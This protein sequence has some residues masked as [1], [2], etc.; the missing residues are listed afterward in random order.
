VVP[1][2]IA[3]LFPLV[4]EAEEY[5]REARPYGVVLG[6]SGLALIAWQA[7]AERPSRRGFV[8][9]GLFLSVAAAVSSHYYAVLI[10]VPLVL[11]ELARSLLRR[12]VDIPMWL[13]LLAGVLPLPLHLPL[14]RIATAYSDRC[15]G[16]A[17]LASIH[18]FYLTL[19][20]P[21]LAGVVALAAIA[22]LYLAVADDQG[23]SQGPKRKATMPLYENVMV[24][25]LIGMPAVGVFLAMAM[26]S[27]FTFRYA[28]AATLGFGIVVASAVSAADRGRPTV[29][30]L[31][32]LVLL[33]H[34]AVLEAWKGNGLRGTDSSQVP[35]VLRPGQYDTLPIVVHDR[36][37]F[38][39]LAHY[40]PPALSS[41][42][43]LLVD[44]DASQRFTGSSYP[45][46]AMLTLSQ[47]VALRVVEY[48]SFL[49]KYDRFLVYWRPMPCGW[50]LAKLAE[51]G[52][53]IELVSH[54]GQEFL[55]L[56]TRK[57]S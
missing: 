30:V 57:G 41:R 46:R 6:W 25:G 2:F 48:R 55:F 40:A 27:L 16:V 1:G 11:G 31:C 18:S 53:R 20:R 26:S 15:W 14:I 39:P 12:S 50:V 8:L 10:L 22:G 32:L 21:A 19:L 49:D 17:N 13:A 38:W 24:A 3:M 35:A 23:E 36:L 5:A 28:L 51:D 45:D 43:T 7:A 37:R 47:S 54:V 42:L 29:G 34:L 56:V 52:A 4:T 33:G 9:V 44:V